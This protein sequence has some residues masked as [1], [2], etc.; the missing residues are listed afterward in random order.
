MSCAGAAHIKRISKFLFPVSGAGATHIS[1]EILKIPFPC[2]V[3][4]RDSQSKENFGK[5]FLDHFDGGDAG[6]AQD[7]VVGLGGDDFG[8]LK[9][10]HHIRRP[11]AAGS[12]L[13]HR[14]ITDPHE[15]LTRRHCDSRI[16]EVKPRER[17]DFVFLR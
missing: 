11:D 7:V 2:V 15:S 13:T 1:R 9:F 14:R 17:E 16:D 5:N 6:V 12:T 10:A 8:H 3:R 4:R